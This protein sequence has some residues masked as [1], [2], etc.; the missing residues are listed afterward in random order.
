MTPETPPQAEAHARRH[1][2]FSWIWLLPLATVLLVGYLVIKLVAERG[3]M[4]SISFESADGLTAQQ[5]Q[6]KYKAV[7]LGTVEQIDLADDLAHVI[8][9]VRMSEQSAALL[10][11]KA[12]FWVARPRLGGGLSSVETGL[13]TLVSGAYVA[14]DPGP[15]GG[16]RKTEFKGLEKPPSVRSDEPGSAY[17]LEAD[18]LGG[19]SEGAPVFYRDVAVG[20]VLSAD[21]DQDGRTPSVR[22]RIFVRAPYDR[23]VVPETRFWNSSG[24]R[25]NVGATGLRL[26]LQSIKSLLSGGIAFR[27]PVEAEQHARSPV[28]S[29]FHLYADEAQAA[30]GF[31]GEGIPYVSY[32]QSSVRG[33]SEGSQVQM[34]GKQLGSVMHIDLVKDPRPG[35]ADQLAARVAFVLQPDRGLDEKDRQTM[36]HDGIRALVR[37]QMRVVLASSSLLTGQKELSLEFVPGSKAPAVLS[38]EA[39]A[40]VLPSEG[41]DLQDLTASLSQILSKVNSIPFEE[42]GSNASHALASL[43]RTV[44]GPELQQAIASLNEALKDMS[45]LAREAK[46]DLGPA[47]ARLPSISE[48]LEK[49]VDQ[50]QAAFGQSGYGSDSK[51][52]RSLERM[53]SQVGDAA[54]S[55][56]LLADYLNRHPESVVSGRKENEP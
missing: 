44:G 3:P 22:V 38:E 40:L 39:G 47:L 21:L 6:V 4:I 25:V 54:R 23:K 16:Q 37:Q 31:F 20:E 51:T 15:K 18:T 32:F 53:M 11:D 42:I 24:I 55:I 28:E 48:K 2:G 7:T 56:R 41:Q 9:K 43:D 30:V 52:Q 17:F 1:V 33:L 12:R 13:E 5:T 27:A 50:A 14:V 46:A 19:L 8:V 26:E 29:S 36:Q 45:G 35:H 10:T 49:A 34:F